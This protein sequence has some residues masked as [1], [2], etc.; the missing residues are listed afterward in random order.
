MIHKTKPA[1]FLLAGCGIFASPLWAGVPRYD[2]EGHCQSVVD[3]TGGSSEIY[4]TCVTGEQRSYDTLKS[5]WESVPA[6]TQS[7]CDKVGQASGG[8]YEILKTCIEQEMQ[9]GSNKQSFDY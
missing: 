9:A 8:S 7:Y 2:V 4:D 3:L 6:R 1:I 5:I